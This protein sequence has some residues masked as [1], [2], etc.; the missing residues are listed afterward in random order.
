MSHSDMWLVVAAMAIATIEPRAFFG[1][2]LIVA[3]IVAIGSYFV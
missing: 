1:A 2:M 3:L